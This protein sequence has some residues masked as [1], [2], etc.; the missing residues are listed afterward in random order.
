MHGEKNEWRPEART[1]LDDARRHGTAFVTHYNE[2]RLHRAIGYIT[3]KGMAC[4]LR[5]TRLRQKTDVLRQHG[6]APST[7]A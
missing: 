6:A 2:A 4:E 1:S 5:P 7:F 3:P